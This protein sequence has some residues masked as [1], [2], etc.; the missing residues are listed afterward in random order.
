MRG[1]PHPMDLTYTVLGLV[2]LAGVWASVG[3][4]AAAWIGLL[5]VLAYLAGGAKFRP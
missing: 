3:A 4:T 1:M 5:L 2:I